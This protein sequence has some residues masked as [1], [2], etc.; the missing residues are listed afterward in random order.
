MA[1]IFIPMTFV[2]GVYGMNFQYMPELAIP[3]AYPVAWLVMLGIAVTMLVYFWRKK[4][5]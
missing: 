4:W 2:A 5:L 1:S 3:W